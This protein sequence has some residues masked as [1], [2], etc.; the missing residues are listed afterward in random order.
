MKIKHFAIFIAFIGLLTTH[1]SAQNNGSFY[2]VYDSNTLFKI[3]KQVPDSAYAVFARHFYLVTKAE[4]LYKWYS[5]IPKAEV[6]RVMKPFVPEAYDADFT[7]ELQKASSKSDFEQLLGEAIGTQS[8]DYV[9]EP[10]YVGD[11][12]AK[13]RYFEVVNT[14]S[15]NGYAE[16]YPFE[17]TN[18]T[19]SSLEGLET[20]ASAIKPYIEQRVKRK[21]I[22]SMASKYGGAFIKG[23]EYIL[24]SYSYDNDDDFF[25][26]QYQ[27]L[28]AYQPETTAIYYT[29][30]SFGGE[31]T[32]APENVSWQ[33]LGSFQQQANNNSSNYNSNRNTSSQNPNARQGVLKLVNNSDNPY[34]VSYVK[35]DIVMQG[36]SEK[37]IYLDYHTLYKLTVKQ[38][39]GFMFS[40]TVIYYDV[41]FDE[42]LTERTIKFPF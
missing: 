21:I 27:V 33:Y 26:Y 15:S 39:S 30:G 36:H 35:G 16:E 25:G 17:F 37:I 11:S 1:C 32:A 2:N 4:E 6:V 24:F 41:Q 3:R 29:V 10:C 31:K 19:F 8:Y 23:E 13:L 38:N 34:T 28:V 5:S 7:S 9:M 12:G 14:M 22:R 20:A 42:N 18:G 40:P